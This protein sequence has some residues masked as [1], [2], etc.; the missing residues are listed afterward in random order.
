MVK[1]PQLS[2]FIDLLYYCNMPTL[3]CTIQCCHFAERQAAKPVSVNTRIPAA[4]G[5]TNSPRKDDEG[6]AIAAINLWFLMLTVR[7]VSIKHTHTLP[8]KS[9]PSCHSTVHTLREENVNVTVVYVLV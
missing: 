7:S 5:V 3:E 1:I 6:E 2:K 9:S 8:V 4:G